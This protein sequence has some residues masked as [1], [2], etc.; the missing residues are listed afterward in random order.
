MNCL[1]GLEIDRL[2]FIEVAG[3]PWCYHEIQGWH[4]QGIPSGSE[5]RLAFGF[6]CADVDGA[7]KGFED[8]PVDWYAVPRFPEHTL[9]DEGPYKR[10]I[11][12]R[13]GLTRKDIPRESGESPIEVRVF[14]D[15]LVRTPEDWQEFKEHFRITPEGRYPEDWDR[16]VAHSKTASHPIV[17][18]IGGFFGVLTNVL[19]LEGETG[20]FMSLYDRPEL[21]REIVE[22][23]IEF[24]IAVIDK[25]LVEARI[26]FVAFGEQIAGDDGPM[27]APAIVKE[28]FLDGYRRVVE[29]V[30]GREID[31]MVFRAD[32]NVLP[33]VP[34]LVDAGFNGLMGVPQKMDMAGLKKRY[35]DN[36]CMIGGIDR[37]AL[38]KSKAE[39]EREVDAKMAVARQGRVI[40]CVDG[41]VT[42]EVSLENYR[43]YA[44]YLRKSIDRLANEG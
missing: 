15:P 3:M 8:V 14:V 1:R 29:H 6:D 42:P 11:D 5:P 41:S 40:L 28:F 37:W 43:H 32:G 18:G 22:H 13:W 23:C 20:L 27:I 7:V 10:R 26:D 9:P 2:P 33:F 19:G 34:M 30:R 39:I 16:W 12:G 31:T 21:V 44:Q 25:A 24:D 36:I 35:G 4:H 17:L 38:T